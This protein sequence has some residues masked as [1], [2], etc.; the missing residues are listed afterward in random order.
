MLV[1]Y[2]GKIPFKDGWTYH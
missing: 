1:T 2:A